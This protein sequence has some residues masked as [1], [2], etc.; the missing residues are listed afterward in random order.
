MP[1]SELGFA[2]LGAGVAAHYYAT[3]IAQTP[4]ARLV[5]MARSEPT[6]AAETAAE[7]GVPCESSYEALLARLDV[8]VVCICTPSGLH[9]NQTRA[10]AQARK[11]VMV[12][13]PLALTLAEADPMIAACHG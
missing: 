2:I 6:R 5:A 12:E 10:A 13:K 3:A 4:G 8:D 7:F 11:H 1:A 9:A